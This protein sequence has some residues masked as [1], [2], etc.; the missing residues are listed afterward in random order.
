[1]SDASKSLADHFSLKKKKK[2]YLT[3]TPSTDL[4]V[5]RFLIN[6]FLCEQK[7]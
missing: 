5:C 1:M 2:T 6:V 3:K 7:T 4:F